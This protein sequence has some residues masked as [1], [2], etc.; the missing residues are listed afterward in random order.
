[1]RDADGRSPRYGGLREQ[2]RWFQSL[3]LGSLRIAEPSSELSI[4]SRRLSTYDLGP[5]YDF[6]YMHRAFLLRVLTTALRLRLRLRL[7]D[8][9]LWFVVEEALLC[10]G[11]HRL[12]G[13]LDVSTLA[14]LELMRGHE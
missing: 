7:A 4:A 2:V 13:R 3:L 12:V 5:T 1:M 14:P 6:D 11:L 10:A 8:V 9:A